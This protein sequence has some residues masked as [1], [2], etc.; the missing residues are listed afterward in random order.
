[1]SLFPLDLRWRCRITSN[2]VITFRTGSGNDKTHTPTNAI[3]LGVDRCMCR[4]R[5]RAVGL[6]ATSADSDCNSDFNRYFDR[7]DRANRYPDTGGYSCS[8]SDSDTFAYRHCDATAYRNVDTHADIVA[9]RYPAPL[10]DTHSDTFAYRHCDAVA[11]R[12]C[13]SQSDRYCDKRTH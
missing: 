1:M 2:T 13:D 4:R 9:D 12:H 10:S 8:D 7:H 3:V 11:D 6:R 5:C